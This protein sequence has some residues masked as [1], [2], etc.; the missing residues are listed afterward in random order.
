MFEEY[1]F[2]FMIQQINTERMDLIQ[3]PLIIWI[4]HIIVDILNKDP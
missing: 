1:I 4:L 3:L 2:V